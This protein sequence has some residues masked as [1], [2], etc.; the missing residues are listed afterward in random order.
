VRINRLRTRAELIVSAFIASLFSAQ[1]PRPVKTCCWQCWTRRAEIATGDRV[2]AIQSPMELD[3]GA[4]L[5]ST[6][7]L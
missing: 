6:S 4:V 3:R 1:A 5:L 7:A 2:A